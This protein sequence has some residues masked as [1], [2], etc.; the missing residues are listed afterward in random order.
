V[1]VAEVIMNNLESR[2]GKEDGAR[3]HEENPKAGVNELVQMLIESDLLSGVGV[4]RV[5]L[6]EDQA[7]PITVEISNPSVKGT[8]GA[9]KAFLFSWWAG[10][11]TSVL[12][13]EL[14]VNNVIYG[15]GKNVMKCEIGPR[16]TK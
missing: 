13:R 9:A 10:A 12:G 11:L 6:P 5:T 2:L 3:L 16:A 15:E 7:S 8:A 1:Q 4:T 14:E